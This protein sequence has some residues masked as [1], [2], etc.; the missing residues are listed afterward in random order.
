MSKTVLFLNMFPD[1][2]PPE[3]LYGLL[4]QADITAADI[5]PENRSVTVAMRSGLYIPQ[6]LLTKASGD[7]CAVYGLRDLTIEPVYPASQLQ[8]MEP[9]DLMQLFVSENSMT[10]GSLAGA[11]WTWEGET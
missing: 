8:S 7:I 9:E 10:R 3:P 6:R 4:S 11:S 1:Y 2:T 5:D